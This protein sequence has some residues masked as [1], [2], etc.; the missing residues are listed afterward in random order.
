MSLRRLSCL[1]CSV[2]LLMCAVLAF[3]IAGAVGTLQTAQALSCQY[4]GT[5]TGGGGGG[6]STGSLTAEETQ[7]A[8]TIIGVT[9]GM[10]LGTNAQVIAIA[11][12]VVESGLINLPGGDRDSAGLFQ[13]R[14]SQGWG[15]YQEVTDPV[16][17]T[18]KFLAALTSIPNWQSIPPGTAAQEVQKSAYP[19][20]YQQAI[21]G[22]Y[23]G[24]PSAPTI[25]GSLASL[26]PAIAP[27]PRALGSGGSSGGGG[28]ATPGTNPCGAGVTGYVN[29][30]QSQWYAPARVD[31]GTDWL[32]QMQDTPVIAIGDATVTYAQ[33]GSAN[34]GW[35]GTP[36]G[37][38]VYTLASGQLAGK[39]IYV[40][41][42]VS[43]TVSAG[44]KITA[45][46]TIAYSHPG[47]AWTEWG[48]A[49]GSGGPGPL[50][51]Y[52]GSPDG[53]CTPGGIAFANFLHDLG[54]PWATVDI[55][56]WAPGQWPDKNPYP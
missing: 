1:G 12:A 19:D 39:S 18:T 55:C 15:T 31:M 5:T 35:P 24:F 50:T 37:C 17:A 6:G 4:S 20:R 22:P 48:W 2:V 11:T 45:G 40:C 14:P 8:K 7:N 34:T 42:N 25:V 16:Y 41:E 44:Q 26:S 36:G 56:P 54:A 10:N 51:P 23:N 9:K 29:P 38:V 3:V 33:T 49:N 27:D 13:Q 21:D 30:I 52:G 53:Y 43:P 28:G 47:Y 46:Q 32:P